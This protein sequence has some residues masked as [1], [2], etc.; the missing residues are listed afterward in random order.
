MENNIMTQEEKSLLL[1]DFC[2][3]LPYGLLIDTTRGA[4]ELDAI[5]RDLISLKDKEGRLS[6]L[7]QFTDGKYWFPIV[8]GNY[9][10]YLRPMESMTKEEEKIF[11][12]L[13]E[14]LSYNKDTKCV[15]YKTECQDFLNK[16]HFDYRGLIP[17][18]L[19]LEAPENM[20]N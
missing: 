10:P 4:F 14:G 3:R 2:A 7:L 20:Y 15:E 11:L 18:G 9:K 1:Q 12:S 5:S 17:M 8:S 19:A 16:H 6:D 13:S